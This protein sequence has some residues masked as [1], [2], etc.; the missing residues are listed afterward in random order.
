MRLQYSACACATVNPP[1]APQYVRPQDD[2]PPPRRPA[3]APKTKD[4][5]IHYVLVKHGSLKALKSRTDIKM[6]ADLRIV[7]RIPLARLTP[8]CLVSTFLLD[9]ITAPVN[10]AEHWDESTENV[11]TS[12]F[13]RVLGGRSVPLCIRVLSGNLTLRWA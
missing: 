8:D 9:K 11:V 12:S 1:R 10:V 3:P 6:P 13:L 2:I 5:R 7:E 4:G